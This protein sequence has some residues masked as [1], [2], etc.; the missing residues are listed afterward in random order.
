MAQRSK[1]MPLGTQTDGGSPTRPSRSV[2]RAYTIPRQETVRFKAVLIGDSKV[3]KTS[4][5]LR[6]AKDRFNEN[7]DST[8]GASYLPHTVELEKT[9][10]KY[11]IWEAA[12]QE[13]Y[14]GFSPNVL[15]QGPSCNFWHGCF[16][17]RRQLQTWWCL[18]C[19]R[20]AA[21]SDSLTRGLVLLSA[22]YIYVHNLRE[23]L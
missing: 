18:P 7:E 3:G 8:I 10:V 15:S 4:L 9:R 2:T 6:Y 17:N 23:L 16:W 11:D 5:A 22:S 19:S 1:S 20:F 14:H 12:G 13:R 21:S